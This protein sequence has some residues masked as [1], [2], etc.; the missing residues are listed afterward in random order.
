MSELFIPGPSMCA[1]EAALAP[2][3]VDAESWLLGS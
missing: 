3:Q 1:V 2:A